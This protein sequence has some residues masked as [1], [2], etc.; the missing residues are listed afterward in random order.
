MT[1][2]RRS[3]PRYRL[4]RRVVVRIGRNQVDAW[5]VDVSRG[6]VRLQMPYRPR[7]EQTLEVALPGPESSTFVTP[8]R[9][10]HVRRH[11]DGVLVG[12]RWLPERSRV[13]P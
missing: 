13:E 9:V 4:R 7:R 2:E 11:P 8:A 5:T 1:D 12:A 3:H 6:G 10:R